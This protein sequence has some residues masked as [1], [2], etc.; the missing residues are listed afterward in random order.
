MPTSESKPVDNIMFKY[1]TWR[2]STPTPR[3]DN[4]F[5]MV[6]LYIFTI[7]VCNTT[8]VIVTYYNL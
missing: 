3:T 8:Q 4:G 7:M 1:G 5:V 6:G 2:V